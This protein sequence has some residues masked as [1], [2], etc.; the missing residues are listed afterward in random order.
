[1]NG[2]EILIN[3]C[4]YDLLD[5][6]WSAGFCCPE[7]ASMFLSMVIHRGK[8]VKCLGFMVSVE[9]MNSAHEPMRRFLMT[10][11]LTLLCKL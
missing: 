7:E 9:V 1:M 3:P 11:P 8:N 2:T 6:F 4:V 10:M 5:E